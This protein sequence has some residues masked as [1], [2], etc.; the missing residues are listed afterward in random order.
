MKG[1]NALWYANHVVLRLN[2]KSQRIG[3]GTIEYG[4]GDFLL[5]VNVS[6]CSGLA[7]IF[8]KQFNGKKIKTTLLLITNRKWHTPC[9]TKWNL[10]TLDDPE[11]R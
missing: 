3:D 10:L 11:S 7:A 5:A 9:Q 8:N 6:I 2:G 1:H 4:G